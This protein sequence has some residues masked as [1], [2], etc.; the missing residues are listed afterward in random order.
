LYTNSDIWA[1]IKD[2]YKLKEVFYLN[3]QRHLKYIPYLSHAFSLKESSNQIVIDYITTR[4]VFVD[5]N[6]LTCNFTDH[7]NNDTELDTTN[8]KTGE[9]ISSSFLLTAS[10]N[11]IMFLFSFI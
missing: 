6:R 5:E 2:Y 4:G 9:K 7:K 1:P 8:R 11:V 10:L 3:N